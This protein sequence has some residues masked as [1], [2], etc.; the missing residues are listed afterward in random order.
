MSVQVFEVEP[1]SPAAKKRIESGDLIVSINGNEIND[2]LDYD[3]YSAEIKLEI[4]IIKKNG[5]SKKIK[6]KKDEYEDIGVAFKTY[7]IDE[8]HR[9]KNNCMFCFID[10]MPKG[11]RESLY[12]KDDD[13]R[14]SFIFGNY[15]T[16]TNLPE[17]EVDRIIKM[18][19]S[20]VNISVHTT[21]PELRAK[22]MNNRFAGESLRYIKKLADAK[23]K[24][25]CQLVLCPGVNDGEEL[26]KSLN[27]LS[28]LY[29]SVESIACVPVGL[30][31]HREGLP[32]IE[33]YNEKTAAEVIDIIEA[34]SSDFLKKNGSRLAYPA[35]E[36]F[37]RAKRKMPAADYYEDF[38]QLENGVGIVA[39]QRK[40]FED[41]LSEIE[42]S[43]CK[44]R[45]TVAT[46]VDAAPFIQAL[47]D[48]LQKKWHNL[49]CKVIAVENE[50]F[51]K[52]ITVAGLLT[53]RD[54]LNRLKDEDLGDELLLPSC[55]LRHEQD[56]FLD[57]MTLS[58][59]KAALN[60]P[61]TLCENDGADILYK[62]IGK[63]I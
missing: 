4:E 7:L 16:L 44:R 34:F 26:K 21:N 63:E 8:H 29:P 1:K 36:F 43:S 49:Y 58:E 6:I 47:V 11:L 38:V 3:F 39:L 62:L 52:T 56:K 61:I 27:E 2:I 23:I 5:K 24:M 14:L 25:N 17:S 53:G 22:M 55:M 57:D 51:G 13:D 10:Q 28:K 54:L 35:D 45:I 32:E 30:T 37:I 42:E 46:G 41:A 9:C 60:I 12:F 18:H 33:P 19:I 20:P 15:I 59:L 40:E 31:S 48:E 50:F